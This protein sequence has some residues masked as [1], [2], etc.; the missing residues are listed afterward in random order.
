MRVLHLVSGSKWTGPAAVAVDQVRALRAA[1]IEAEIGFT[2]PGG[3]ASRFAA[4]GWA[5]PLLTKPRRPGHF[6]ADLRRVRDTL[7]REHFDILHAHHSHDHMVAAVAARGGRAAV[8]RTF[9]QARQSRGLLAWALTAATRGWAFSNSSIA[10]AFPDDGRP[11]AILPPVVD[12]DRF[13]PGPRDEG[14]ARRFGLP[15]G[16]FVVGTVGKIAPGRGHDRALATLSAVNEPRVVMLHV[17]K[18]EWQDELDRRAAALGLGQ[19]NIRVGYQEEL[20]PELYRLMDVFLFPAAGSDEGHRAIGEAVAS[21][22]PFV[23]FPIPGVEDWKAGG[24]IAQDEAAAAREIAGLA[25]DPGDL[26]RRGAAARISAA[27]C[28]P[29]AFVARAREFYESLRREETPEP[30]R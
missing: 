23:A 8:V 22:V 12:L 6:A 4:D 11:R 24:V 9:H 19:R 13:R 26:A 7:A 21:G 25:R 27:A 29:S 28:S 17:G 1:G 20:L 15:A 14:L 2:A 5:R 16:A 30:R 3:L 18:G 10:E